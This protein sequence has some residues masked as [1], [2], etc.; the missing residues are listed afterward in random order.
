MIVTNRITVTMKR[1]NSMQEKQL[2]ISLLDVVLRN[3]YFKNRV[4]SEQSMLWARS[5]YLFTLGISQQPRTFEAVKRQKLL[6]TI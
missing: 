4:I 5:R 3:S 2:W 6:N 1:G